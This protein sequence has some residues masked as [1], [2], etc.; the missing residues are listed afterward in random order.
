[1]KDIRRKLD[2]MQTELYSHFK[3]EHKELTPIEIFESIPTDMKMITDA[4]RKYFF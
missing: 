4:T 3:V 2:N 1:M